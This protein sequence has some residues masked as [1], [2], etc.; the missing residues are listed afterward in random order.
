[1]GLKSEKGPLR[2]LL[3]TEILALTSTVLIALFEKMASKQGT[4]FLPRF[5][6]GAPLH[7]SLPGPSPVCLERPY[8]EL[9]APDNIALGSLG[10]SDP[11]T[12][13]R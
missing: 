2:E 11:T 9:I 13:I 4:Q 6:C 3:Q 12:L 10:L 1:M 7:L 8:Q 5:P